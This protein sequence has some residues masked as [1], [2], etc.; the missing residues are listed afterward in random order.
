TGTLLQLVNLENG[1]KLAQRFIENYA[2]LDVFSPNGLVLAMEIDAGPD[3][4]PRPINRNAPLGAGWRL[5]R[6]ELQEVMS[7]RQL[8]ILP[9]APGIYLG[10]FSPDG[11]T[12]AT[13]TYQ[14]V[15]RD[16]REH[17]DQQSIHLSEIVTGQDR[18]TIRLAETGDL[19]NITKMLFGPDGRT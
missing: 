4:T 5:R 3:P 1:Q 17:C 14:L 7:G 6:A 13:S 8:A 18:L 15:H 11:Q 2:G 9:P 10:G 16:G 12:V 19:Q